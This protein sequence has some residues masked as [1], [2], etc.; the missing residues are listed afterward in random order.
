[1]KKLFY[2]W[3]ASG[4]APCPN[5]RLLSRLAAGGAAAAGLPRDIDWNLSVRFVRDAAM[6]S[7]NREF[8]GHEGTTDV[9]TFNYLDA[10]DSFFPGDTGIE[11]I[12]CADAAIRE[13]AKR[14]DS[15]Y[16]GEMALYLT[17]GLLHCAG[18]DDLTPETAVSMRR[19]EQEVLNILK[20][21]FDFRLVFPPPRN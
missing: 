6:T 5:R 1:M 3:E 9:I 18:E 10:L 17:H 13:G 11:L 16:S 4:S 7:A 14:S 15:G 19:R 8:V 21:N 20:R 12:I 2:R